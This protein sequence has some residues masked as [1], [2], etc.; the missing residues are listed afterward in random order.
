M[1]DIQPAAAALV[2]HD[3]PA[4]SLPLGR[5]SH[6]GNGQPNDKEADEVDA[7]EKVVLSDAS[8]EGSADERSLRGIGDAFEQGDFVECYAPIDTYEG[9]HRYDPKV[10][11]DHRMNKK[12]QLYK[13]V[14]NIIIA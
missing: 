12:Q 6:R 4:G 14:P 13:K 7:K 1:A 8:S 10:S 9:R 3:T 2:D 5:T 11:S